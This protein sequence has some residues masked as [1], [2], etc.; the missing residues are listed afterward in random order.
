VTSTLKRIL[1]F[2]YPRASW[3]YDIIVLGILAFIF[4]TPR[5]WFRDQ[6]RASSIVLLPSE[7]QGEGVFY[8]E[9]KLLPENSEAGRFASAT[10]LLERHDGKKYQLTRLTTH[11]D[12]EGVVKGFIAYT[13]LV[14]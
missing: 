9:A 12:S 1:F 10:R 13:K 6:P 3:Q 8:L 7:A 14:K 5:E 11:P 4:L 2:E